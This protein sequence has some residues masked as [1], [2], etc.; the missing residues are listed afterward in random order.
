MPFSKW[1]ILLSKTVLFLPFLI[2]LFKVRGAFDL[3]AM[4]FAGF[5]GI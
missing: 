2:L 5:G 4:G 1:G 3:L